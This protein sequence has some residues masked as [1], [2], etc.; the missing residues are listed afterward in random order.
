MDRFSKYN[1]KATLLYFVCMITAT[2]L[3]FNPIYLAISLVAAVCCQLISGRVKECVNA[4]KLAFPVI[5]FIG[6]FNMLFVHK[7]TTVLFTLYDIN[8]TL[9]SLVYGICQGTLFAAV[10]LWIS[11]YNSVVSAEGF[12]AVFGRLS[13]NTV[14][15]FSLTLTFIP[16]LKKNLN[17]I[18]D[19]RA[20]VDTHKS[21]MKKALSNL[22]ALITMTLEESVETALSM[23]ARGFN[24]KRTVY[25]K[26]RFSMKDALVTA[27][28]IILLAAVLAARLSRKTLF[29]YEPVIM[30]PYV[31]IAAVSAFALLAFMPSIINILE[32]IK[33][34]LSRRKI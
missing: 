3:V 2:L 28:E 17:E 34:Q 27:A 15:V 13:P 30:V 18:N 11:C 24:N 12:M 6:I 25:A 14:L 22:S 8:F 1:P 16:R 32:N 10:I 5:V 9:E 20:L 7:G 23:K 21:K 31:S 19:S 4:V 29:V 26:Y 33:W